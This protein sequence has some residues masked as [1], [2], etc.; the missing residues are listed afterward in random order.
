MDLLRNA[1]S[2][3][4]DDEEQPKRQRLSHSSSNPSKR[5]LPSPSPPLIHQ[6]QP[7]IPGS[8][9]SK[10]QRALMGPTPPLFLTWFL[11]FLRSRYQSSRCQ[12]TP[13]LS[14]IAG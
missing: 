5:H 3:V 8:Y 1:Y 14:D 7:P 11:F 2:N 6:K 4:S 9:I 10:R 13:P 12:M